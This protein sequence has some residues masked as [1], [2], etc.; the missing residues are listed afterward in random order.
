MTFAEFSRK[1]RKRSP[2]AFPECYGSNGWT[3]GDWG[4]ALGGEAGE[5]QNK[6]KKIRRGES[7]DKDGNLK[8]SLGKELADVIAYCDLIAERSGINLEAAL[9]QKFNEVSVK[10]GSR[11]FLK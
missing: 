11:I 6:I 5:A 2:Q 1:N 7:V 8:V 3:L 4:N 10:K 9:I